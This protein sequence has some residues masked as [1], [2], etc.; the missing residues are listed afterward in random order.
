MCSSDLN[1]LAGLFTKAAYQKTKNLAN[2]LERG[3][4]IFGLSDFKSF[5]SAKESRMLVQELIQD[6]NSIRTTI[7]NVTEFYRT[8]HFNPNLLGPVLP[9]ISCNP[10][11]PEVDQNMLWQQV[12][13]LF[14]FFR[15]YK[16]I[17]ESALKTQV[18][19]LLAKVYMCAEADK[20]FMFC[21]NGKVFDWK[22]FENAV[23]DVY[24][25][26]TYD[27]ATQWYFKDRDSSFI[28]H[29]RY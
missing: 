13:W 29:Y 3:I 12:F 26:Q 6:C 4:N 24:L 10:G 20:E 8:F 18:R 9:F 21:I 22:I 7:D 1:I 15:D 16:K 27:I 11:A 2:S 14:G 28:A 5:I 25:L 19:L 17:F 23:N